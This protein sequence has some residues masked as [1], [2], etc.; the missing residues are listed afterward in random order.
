[1]DDPIPK[2]PEKE[3]GEFLTIDGYPDVKKPCMF[4]KGIYFYLFYC[5]SYVKDI[6]TDM[7]EE[8]VSEERYPE[9]NEM[10]NIRME[11]IKGE[12]WMDFAEDGEDKSN[13]HALRWDVYTRDK[14]ELIKREFLV[15]VLHKK[16]GN[17]VWNF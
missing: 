9:L 13:I 4:E 16:G 7:S 8:Q 11:D 6:S 17:I 3:Q 5:F 15:S 1:M 2:L 14:E 12:H 10:E